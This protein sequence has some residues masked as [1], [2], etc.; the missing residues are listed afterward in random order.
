M[1]LRRKL[2]IR[3]EPRLVFGPELFMVR[4]V[5]DLRL[6]Y[7]LKLYILRLKKDGF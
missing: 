1:E 4:L 7:E 6:H 3:A 2:W 5:I